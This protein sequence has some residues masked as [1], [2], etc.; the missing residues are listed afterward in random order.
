M[1]ASFQA[2]VYRLEGLRQ[3]LFRRIRRM[4]RSGLAK[5]AAKT[6]PELMPEKHCFSGHQD[7]FAI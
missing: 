2:A 1:K 5:Q 7:L 4:R 6:S 3:N